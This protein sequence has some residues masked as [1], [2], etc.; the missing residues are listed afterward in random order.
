MQVGPFAVVRRWA[1]DQTSVADF[2]FVFSEHLATKWHDPRYTWQ[3]FMLEPNTNSVITAPS[4]AYVAD[5]DRTR[6]NTGDP[7][8]WMESYPQG[9]P[10][11]RRLLRWAWADPSRVYSMTSRFTL[12]HNIPFVWEVGLL[13]SAG[14]STDHQVFLTWGSNTRRLVLQK[15]RPAL[16]QLNDAGTWRTLA[17]LPLDLRYAWRDVGTDLIWIVP[18]WQGV[19]IGTSAEP[20]AWQFVRPREGLDS[21]AGQVAVTGSGGVATF[22]VHDVTLATATVTSM[23]IDPGVAPTNPGSVV[24]WGWLDNLGGSYATSLVAGEP[25]T[26]RYA[27]TVTPGTRVM[28]L[29]KVDVVHDPELVVVRAA[30][31]LTVNRVLEVNEQLNETPADAVCTVVLDDDAGAYAGQFARYEIVDWHFGWLHDTGAATQTLRGTGLITAVRER[32]AA[33]GEAQVELT[34]RPLLQSVRDGTVVYVPDYTGWLVPDAL[35]DFLVRH[36]IPSANISIDDTWNSLVL[37]AGAEP[38]TWQP[39][40]GSSAWKWLD[41][42][43]SY[44]LGG[45]VL[46]WPDGTVRIEP[47]AEVEDWD[48]APEYHAYGPGDLVGVTYGRPEDALEEVRNVVVVMGMDPFGFPLAAVLRDEASLY[49]PAADNYVGYP[50]PLVVRDSGLSTQEIVNWACATLYN[51][52]RQMRNTI[53]FEIHPRRGNEDLFPGEFIRYQRPDGLVDMVLV[54]ACT[55][56]L[57]HGE[58]AQTVAG[59]YVTVVPGA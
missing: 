27:V 39:E 36:G 48:Q 22:G 14:T 8:W 38:G 31:P 34:L 57:A 29:A 15:R 26:Y 43:V 28:G 2:G 21:P 49:D 7:S 18:Y 25:P 24:A 19:L 59:H 47:Y 33:S 23:I 40:F 17:E 20:K 45:W 11:G 4:I 52:Y 16:L 10:E 44:L 30:D 55:T 1:R 5:N 37:P 32:R 12:G 9:F 6:W 3:G 58:F 53:E 51:R 50:K 56:R 46:C 54:R 42:V 41:D 35:R 13:P